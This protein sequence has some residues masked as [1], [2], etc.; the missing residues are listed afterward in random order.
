MEI[1]TR[2]PS[3]VEEI[4]VK[5]GDQVAAKTVLA[6]VEAMKMSQA[7]PCPIDGVVT[8]IKVEKGDR[9]RAGAVLMIV[10]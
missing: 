1:K 9:I 5:E 10:E 7:I 3:S 6:K 4:L 8:E 2:V